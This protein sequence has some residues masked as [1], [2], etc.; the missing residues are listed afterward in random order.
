MPRRPTRSE[1]APIDPA[2]E[3]PAIRA[4]LRQLAVTSALCFGAL[5]VLTYLL[6]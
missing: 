2:A 5:A 6:R 3:Y 4:D 1:P